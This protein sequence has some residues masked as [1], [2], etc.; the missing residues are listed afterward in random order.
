MKPAKKPAAASPDADGIK[1][2]AATAFMRAVE[3]RGEALRRQKLAGE[4]HRAEEAWR[5]RQ[6]LLPPV[7]L[8]EEI[9][10]ALYKLHIQPITDRLKKLSPRDGSFKEHVR[11]ES[12]PD[13]IPKLKV[14]L[15]YSQGGEIEMQ[16]HLRR[17]NKYFDVAFTR[18]DAPEAEPL[19]KTFSRIKDLQSEIGLFVA[20]VAYNR[21]TELSIIDRNMSAHLR[22]ASTRRPRP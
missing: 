20:E 1:L 17:G 12:Y 6:E 19:K 3:K 14:H 5:R 22:P 16:M 2:Q 13:G 18:R 10:K 11:F 7:D 8:R 4:N 21:R 15:S 9:Q